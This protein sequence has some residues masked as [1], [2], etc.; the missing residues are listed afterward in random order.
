[1]SSDRHNNPWLYDLRL[2]DRNLR[3]GALDDKELSRYL[4]TLKDH[5][6]ET[7]TFS[8]AQPALG[9]G[10]DDFDDEDEVDGAEETPVLDA[11][12]AE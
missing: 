7:D 3:S 5:E 2:R 8:L 9:D 12:Q 10:E 1:M 11:Q 6:G 4:G